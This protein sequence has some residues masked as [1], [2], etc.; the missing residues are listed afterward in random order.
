MGSW[1]H[2]WISSLSLYFLGGEGCGGADSCGDEGG[3]STDNN[4]SSDENQSNGASYHRR[5]I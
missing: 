1:G 4:Q 5:K 3:D 2:F